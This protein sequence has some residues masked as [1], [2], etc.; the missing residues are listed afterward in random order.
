MKREQKLNQHEYIFTKKKDAI[1][2]CV[3]MPWQHDTLLYSA[4]SIQKPSKTCSMIL[5]LQ[6]DFQ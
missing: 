2:T 1:Y 5:Y 4:F 6:L 3:H